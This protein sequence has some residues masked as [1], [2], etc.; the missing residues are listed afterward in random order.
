MKHQFYA[1]AITVLALYACHGD[2][3]STIDPIVTQYLAQE[4]TIEVRWIFITQF[5][6][7][8]DTLPPIANSLK[9]VWLEALPDEPLAYYGQDTLTQMLLKVES[10]TSYQVT[11]S[12]NGAFSWQYQSIYH[13][14]YS[15]VIEGEAIGDSI[16]FGIYTRNNSNGE[17]LGH[18]YRGVKQ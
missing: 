18:Y 6:K 4:T 13:T 8:L 15:Y 11:M 1:I 9:K 5:I 12:Q 10:D 16:R 3:K 14:P 2:E 7:E 17:F